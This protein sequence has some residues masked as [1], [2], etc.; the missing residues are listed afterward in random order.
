VRANALGIVELTNMFESNGG[1]RIL[2][3]QDSTL[4]ERIVTDVFLLSNL[5]GN[6]AFG[7]CNFL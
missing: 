2:L 6:T 5:S 1:S 4:G 3:P 7:L